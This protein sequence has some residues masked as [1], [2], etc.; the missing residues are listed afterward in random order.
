MT[1]GRRVMLLTVSNK[2]IDAALTAEG[3]VEVP[4]IHPV[5]CE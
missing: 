5:Y 4:G 1:V 2:P 3:R